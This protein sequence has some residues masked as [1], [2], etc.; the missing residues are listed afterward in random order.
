[1]NIDEIKIGDITMMTPYV[2]E[3]NKKLL[4]DSESMLKEYSESLMLKI[5]KELSGGDL[6]GFA[7]DRNPSPKDIMKAE[8]TYLDDPFRNYLIKR[9]GEV[10]GLVERP[11]LLVNTAT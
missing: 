5:K 8:R 4:A 10:K 6:A 7:I 2:A 11:R 3:E 1:M 9:L